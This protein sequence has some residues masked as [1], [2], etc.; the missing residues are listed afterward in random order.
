MDQEAICSDPACSGEA[1]FLRKYEKDAG[2]ALGMATCP[3]LRVMR[4][5]GPTC[6]FEE[7]LFPAKW[8]RAVRVVPPFPL[9]PARMLTSGRTGAASLSGVSEG[10]GKVSG[11][12][13]GH[14]DQAKQRTGNRQ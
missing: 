3:A 11:D 12:R 2:R 14:S 5:W 10:V 8:L 13:G 1:D 7:F 4:V 9:P 6:V